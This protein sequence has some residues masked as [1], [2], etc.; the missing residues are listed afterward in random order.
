MGGYPAHLET[1]VVLRDGSTVHIRPARPDDSSRSR[2]TSSASP[3]SRG[4]CASSALVGRRRR[5]GGERG[6]SRRRRPSHAARVH[7]RDDERIVGGAQYIREGEAARRDGAVSVTDELQG[8]GLASILIGHLAQAATSNGI[9]FFAPQVLPENHRMIDVFRHA[10][11]PVTLRT[12]PGTV[13]IEFPT[14][15]S[16]ETAEQLRGSASGSRAQTR[17]ARCSK[18]PSVAVIGASRDPATHRRP[19]AEEPARPAVRGRRASGEPQQRRGAGR[20][21]VPEHRRTSPGRV[22][23]AFV[24]VPA[25]FV[26]DVA[27]GM[28]REGGARA[29]RHLGRLRA[30]PARTAAAPGRAAR[31]VPRERHAARSARTAWA[32]S[33]PIPT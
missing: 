26:L 27:Q 21:R 13:E 19:A 12:R 7:R 8:Q 11:F 15:V 3:T 9:A 1:D 24:A 32:S 4:G 25:P 10:G 33:T 18:P 5:A 29:R 22:D 16:D 23:V 30:R 28:R 14:E 17:S 31:R 20:S 6:R 2:T